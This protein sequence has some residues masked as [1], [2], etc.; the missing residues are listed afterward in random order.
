MNPRFG[1]EVEGMLFIPA[2]GYLPLVHYQ[3]FYFDE[4]NEE[5]Q[6]ENTNGGD[7]PFRFEIS[8]SMLLQLRSIS[9]SLGDSL[10]IGF[11]SEH[12]MSMR[13]ND[14]KTFTTTVEKIYGLYVNFF[15]NLNGGM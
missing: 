12:L 9:L 15:F 4:K 2:V 11:F 13:P 10:A 3:I 1:E 14:T 6:I 7:N 8:K 5:I